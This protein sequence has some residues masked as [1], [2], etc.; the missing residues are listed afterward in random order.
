LGFYTLDDLTFE[1]SAN[2]VPEPSS[3][4]LLAV[5]LLGLRRR[6]GVGLR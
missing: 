6:R 1:S 5:G 3:L 2:G 4:A